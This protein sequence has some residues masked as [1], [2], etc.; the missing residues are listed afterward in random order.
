MYGDSNR[1]CYSRGEISSRWPNHGIGQSNPQQQQYNRMQHMASVG[2]H[3]PP[4]PLRFPPQT[5]NGSFVNP[6]R[7]TAPLHNWPHSPGVMHS[8]RA[9]PSPL[10][11]TPRSPFP[12]PA[13]SLAQN[14]STMWMIFLRQSSTSITFQMKIWLI[15]FLNILLHYQNYITLLVTINYYRY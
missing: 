6:P 10:R 15:I 11:K 7:Q 8:P 9:T 1:L 12:H 2:S 4:P 13:Y 3:M 5:G 14:K